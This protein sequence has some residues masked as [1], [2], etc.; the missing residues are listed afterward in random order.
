M[1]SKVSNHLFIG[2]LTV[3]LGVAGATIPSI[4]AQAASTKSVTV[5]NEKQLTAALK[6]N[7]VTMITI[8]D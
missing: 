4:H 3:I 7:K 6:E 8:K 5:T 2:L 1:K